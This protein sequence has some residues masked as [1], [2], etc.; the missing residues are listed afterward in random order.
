MDLDHEHVVFARNNVFGVDLHDKRFIPQHTDIDLF[1]FDLM[2]AD[3]LAVEVDPRLLVNA[4][5]QDI[6]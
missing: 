4:H 2:S 3:R 5:K 1:G 6:Q